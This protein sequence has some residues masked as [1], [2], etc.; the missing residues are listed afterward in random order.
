MEKADVGIAENG[1]YATSTKRQNAWKQEPRKV[2]QPMILL[3]ACI[4][5]LGAL[6]VFQNQRE[7]SDG[8]FRVSD[9]GGGKTKLNTTM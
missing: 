9:I 2:K 1:A 6:W 7:M 3:S 8:C 4:I 5:I